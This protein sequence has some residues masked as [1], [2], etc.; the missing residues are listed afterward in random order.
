M[1][2]VPRTLPQCLDTA[3]LV[4]PVTSSILHEL[5]LLIWPQVSLALILR[6]D[7]FKEVPRPF[8]SSWQHP[9]PIPP[10]QLVCGPDLVPE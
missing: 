6:L 3:L 1:V 5:P 7:V 4:S 10:H 9:D 8:L 2:E